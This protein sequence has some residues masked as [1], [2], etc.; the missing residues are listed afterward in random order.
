MMD[1]AAFARRNIDVT[2]LPTRLIGGDQRHV[3]PLL[4]LRKKKVFA[5][6]DPGKRGRISQKDLR[7]PA[8]NRN[9]PG[10]PRTNCPVRN[11]RAI[12]REHGT[13]FGHRIMGELNRIPGRKQLDVNIPSAKKR[14]VPSNKRQHAPVGRKRWVHYGVGK[15]C[16]LLPVSGG[17]RGTPA[18][19]VIESD[20]RGDQK[21]YDQP[22]NHTQPQRTSADRGLVNRRCLTRCHASAA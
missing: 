10:V 9:F 2:A 12:G 1:H 4:D 5:A 8:Q 15:K 3:Q 19:V 21:Q 6:I 7:L 18:Q 13:Q 16:H 14:V 20:A 22:R 17:G 11:A